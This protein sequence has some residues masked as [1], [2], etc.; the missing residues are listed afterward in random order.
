MNRRSVSL[1]AARDAVALRIKKR[2]QRERVLKQRGITPTRLVKARKDRVEAMRIKLVRAVVDQRD[3][4]CRIAK[5]AKDGPMSVWAEECEGPSQWCHFAEKK[6]AR[7]RK[8]APEIRHTTEHSF[9]ACAAHHRE[10][11]R[12]DLCIAAVT[13]AGCDGELEY[14]EPE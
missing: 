14:W 11:D 10:Y 12:G 7:T 13:D 4:Y 5:D 1:A 9:M 2:R 6:R 3:G 8:Q